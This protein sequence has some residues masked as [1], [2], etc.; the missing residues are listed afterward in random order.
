MLS[1]AEIDAVLSVLWYTYPIRYTYEDRALSEDEF[2]WRN[3][4]GLFTNLSR[5][6]STTAYF[7][8]CTFSRTSGSGLKG[9]PS[10]LLR[11]SRLRQRM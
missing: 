8:L 10:W 4:G 5:Y 9:L 6:H 11:A 3:N 1:S 2:M 7:F